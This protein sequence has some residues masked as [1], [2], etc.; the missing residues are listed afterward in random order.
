MHALILLPKSCKS[1]YLY[2][3]ESGLC[4]NVRDVVSHVQTI[5]KPLLLVIS[6][7]MGETLALQAGPVGETIA[8]HDILL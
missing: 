3:V 2:D 5:A 4:L 1:F 7:P 6:G 8:K